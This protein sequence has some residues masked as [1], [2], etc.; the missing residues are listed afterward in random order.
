MLLDLLRLDYLDIA[1]AVPRGTKLEQKE[2]HL[3][4]TRHISHVIVYFQ[5]LNANSFEC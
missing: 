4:D 1:G 5:P 3:R 2:S